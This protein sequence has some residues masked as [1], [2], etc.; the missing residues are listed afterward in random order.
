M[1]GGRRWELHHL[2]LTEDVGYSM[3]FVTSL[4]RQLSVP[5]PVMDAMIRIASIVAGQ[6][7]ATQRART[8]DTMGLSGLTRDQLAAF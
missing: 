7:F 2:Y 8:V 4:A 5:T 3:V 6:D 1:P